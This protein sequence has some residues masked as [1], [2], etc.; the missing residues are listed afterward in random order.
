MCPKRD[1]T[2]ETGQ[3]KLPDRSADAKGLFLPS[4]TEEFHIKRKDQM[5]LVQSVFFYCLNFLYRA[6]SESLLLIFD[7]LSDKAG[8]QLA[9]WCVR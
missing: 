3:Q 4:V 6:C 7:T 9:A 5:L 2:N 1:E 8:W